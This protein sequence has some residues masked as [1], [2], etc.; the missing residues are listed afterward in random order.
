MLTYVYNDRVAYYGE[1]SV[2]NYRRIPTS[3]PQNER[4]RLEMHEPCLVEAVGALLLKELPV[5]YVEDQS[6]SFWNSLDILQDHYTLELVA[7]SPPTYRIGPMDGVA[8]GPGILSKTC[9]P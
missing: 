2:L 9:S 1:R 8:N 4:F 3:D 5:Y 6:P 7:D